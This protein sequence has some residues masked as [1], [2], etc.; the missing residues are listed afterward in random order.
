MKLAVFVD[1]VFWFDGGVYSTDEAYVLFPSSFTSAFDEVIFIGRLATRVGRKPYVLSDPSIRFVPI[2]YYQSVYDLW[3][4]GRKLFGAIRELLQT[5]AAS[6]DVI[7][8]CGPNPVANYIARACVSLKRP[9]FLVVRQDLPQQVACVTS[10]LRKILAVAAA[11][12]FERDFKKLARGRTVFTV[13][14]EV[15]RRYHRITDRTHVHYASMISDSQLRAFDARLPALESGRLLCVGRL[16][17]E[18]GYHYLLDAL[19]QPTLRNIEWTLDFI[20]LGPE[21]GRL[22]AQARSYGLRQR[23]RFQGY[24]RFGPELF[25]FFREASVLVVPSLT[26]AFPQVI[27][28]AFSVGVPVIATAVGAIP[29]VV[30]HLKHALLVPPGDPFA[31]A[32]AVADVLGSPDLRHTLAR[33]GRALMRQYTLEQQRNRL[34]RVIHDEILSNPATAHGFG[35]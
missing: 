29:S 11:R 17:R 8:I 3:R 30:Q 20:G 10:G 12:W 31:L 2:P 13:G 9:F 25:S 22:E 32:A 6:W 7:W 19:A 15:G 28:E 5:H 27:F 14:S 34:I 1:Q 21:L 23:V 24:V 26:E 33:N 35:S 18:K 4:T 16:S